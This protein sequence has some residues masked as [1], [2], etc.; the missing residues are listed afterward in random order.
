MKYKIQHRITTLAHNAII[1]KDN[2]ASF[3]IDDITLSQW[4]FNHAYGWK[5][6]AWLAEATFEAADFHEAFKEFR[7]K[8][9]QII[10]KIALISQCYIDFVNES[11]LIHRE[12]SDTAFIRIVKDRSPVGLMFMEDHLK[13]L[14]VLHRNLQIP[15]EF[16]FYWNDAT[17]ATG[18]S[19]KLL[20]MF[21]AIEALAK[22]NDKKD[23]NFIE[24][25]LGK[26]LKIELFGIKG[27][28]R[29]GLR[30]RLVHGEYFN[31]TDS[32]KDYFGEVHKRILHY[33]NSEI[34]HAK[35]LHENVTNPQRHFFGNA[36]GVSFFIQSKT[37]AYNF[38]LKQTILEFDEHDFVKDSNYKMVFDPLLNK[39]Y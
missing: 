1:G 3:A 38:N 20:L 12:D 21:S 8:L 18:Y 22:R 5:G 4:D 17:N 7:L 35:L 14:D 24:L 25:I 26:E 28:S 13:A 39:T 16:Y 19:S 30:H 10:P 23:F 27:N 2:P 6:D 36:E 31:G 11:F 15:D 32:G 37:E 34:F 29:S 9:L 33:F